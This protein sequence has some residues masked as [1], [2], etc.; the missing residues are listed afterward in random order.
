M[1]LDRLLGE[2]GSLDKLALSG[3]VVLVRFRRFGFQNLLHFV[4]K[5]HF[6]LHFIHWRFQITSANKLQLLVRSQDR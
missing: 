6:S 3:L 1:V 4:Y 2:W 5:L